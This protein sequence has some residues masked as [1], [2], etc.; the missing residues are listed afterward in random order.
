[1]PSTPTGDVWASLGGALGTSLAKPMREG[2]DMLAQQKMMQMQH[3]QLQSQQN[4]ERSTF[5][6][7]LAPKI[8]KE[9]AEFISSLSPKE[10]QNLWPNLD[11]IQARLNPE[12]SRTGMNTLQQPGQPGQAQPGQPGQQQQPGVPSFA[13]MFESP[14]MKLDRE[15][16]EVK[17]GQLEE[18]KRANLFKENKGL[19]TKVIDEYKSNKQQM[20]ILDKMSALD[21]ANEVDNPAYLQGLKSLGIDLDFLK[22]PGTIQLDKLSMG[23]LKDL[24]SIFGGRISNLEM[25]NFLKT[26]PTSSQTKEGRSRVIRDLKLM[27]KAKDLRFKAMRDLERENGG[28]LPRDADAQIEERISPKLDK[29]FQKFI[30][31]KQKHKVGSELT[32]LPSV[33]AMPKGSIIE[34]QNGKRLQNDGTSWTEVKKI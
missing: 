13:D 10:R 32:D 15:K 17:K 1:M 5:V 28:I 30:T 24:K 9:T 11:K 6:N 12:M 25:Q 19:R 4:A 21:D 3:A 16:F 33:S 29:I 20:A 22:S 8:G 34:D 27:G 23:M 31:G 14:H 18:Q 2:L 7:N 26:I